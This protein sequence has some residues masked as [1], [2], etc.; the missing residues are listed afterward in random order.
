MS[1]DLRKNTQD[2]KPCLAWKNS[3]AVTVE[4]LIAE[5]Y[6]PEMGPIYITQIRQIS[7]DITYTWNLKNK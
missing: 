6:W 5:V 2:H 3:Q 7:Y 1:K 4:N